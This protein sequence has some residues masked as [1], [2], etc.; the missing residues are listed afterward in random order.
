MSTVTRNFENVFY[1][2]TRL[3]SETGGNVYSEH[4]LYGLASVKG[5]VAQKILSEFVSADELLNNFKLHSVGG[6]IFS[7]RANRI[8]QRAIE[9]AAIKGSA[10]ATEHIL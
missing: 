6:A 7:E 5:S 1:A 2:A 10:A 9:T 8:R 3:A 4:I